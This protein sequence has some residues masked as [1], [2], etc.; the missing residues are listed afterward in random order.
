MSVG[1]HKDSSI[2]GEAKVCVHAMPQIKLVVPCMVNTPG[3]WIIKLH[4]I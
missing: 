1:S 3:D 2:I 4:C